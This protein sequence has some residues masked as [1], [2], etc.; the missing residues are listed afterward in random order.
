MH[1]KLRSPCPAS[2]MSAGTA[3][4]LS[5]SVTTTIIIHSSASGG[6]CNDKGDAAANGVCVEIKEYPSVV[7][8]TAE[9][10][11][12][13]GAMMR[14]GWSG[15][16]CRSTMRCL[17][18]SRDSVRSIWDLYSI[19]ETNQK[20][21]STNLP[22]IQRPSPPPSRLVQYCIAR[23]P[24]TTRHLIKSLS[25]AGQ[26]VASHHDGKSNSPRKPICLAAAPPHKS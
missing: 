9:R 6:A 1:V 4:I 19:G 15:R 18:L 13:L 25:L 20:Q 23:V 10:A 21:Y 2:I 16:T 7:G 8:W 3:S 5:S 26:S 11:L 17:D 22:C 14:C 24:S 12:T